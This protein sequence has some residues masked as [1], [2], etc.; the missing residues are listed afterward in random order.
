MDKNLIEAKRLWEKFTDVCIDENEC[1]ET[2]FEDFEVGTSR[3]DIWHWFED[4]F[5]VSVG[6]DLM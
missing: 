5:G 6:N 3:Y 2:P 4:K 1:I